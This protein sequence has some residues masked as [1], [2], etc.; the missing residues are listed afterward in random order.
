[1]PLEAGRP[2]LARTAGTCR[3]LTGAV[4][5]NQPRMAYHDKVQLLGHFGRCPCLLLS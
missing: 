4:S 5:S 1:M 3:V 2:P